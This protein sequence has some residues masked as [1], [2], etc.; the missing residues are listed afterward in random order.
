MTY[1][2]RST[3]LAVNHCVFSKH[4]D[5]SWRRDHKGRH[6]RAGLFA[7]HLPSYGCYCAVCRRA[8][9]DGAAGAFLDG[10]SE[11]TTIAGAPVDGF[12]RVSV[13]VLVYRLGLGMES[14]DSVGFLLRHGW[15]VFFSLCVWLYVIGSE[16]PSVCVC[17]TPTPNNNAKRGGVLRRGG[18]ICTDP[19]QLVELVES[20]TGCDGWVLVHTLR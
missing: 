18:A 20:P 15:V 4:N 19:A 13:Y 6:H 1:A 11:T 9:V 10:H 2:P 14:I 8:P 7:L 5:L 12:V 16:R 3:Y 17:N